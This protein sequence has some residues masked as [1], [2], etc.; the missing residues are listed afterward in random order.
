MDAQKTAAGDVRLR[1]VEEPD[2]A[3]FFEDQRD[4]AGAEMAIFA[5]RGKDDHFAHWRKILADESV[6]V[7]TIVL[8]EDV[9]G[10]VVSWIQDEERLVGYWV[11][12]AFWGRGIASEAVKLFVN[13]LHE[14][15]LF[16]YVARTNAGSIRVLERC[17][18]TVAGHTQKPGDVEELVYV[19]RG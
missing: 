16:A 10:N 8:G 12:R 6:V 17:G 18:F 2:I 14:R 1:D 13:E 7:R 19:L 3:T 9:A 15:P 11:S 4:P 5:S